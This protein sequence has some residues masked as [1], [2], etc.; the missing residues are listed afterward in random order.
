M[1]PSVNERPSARPKSG[2]DRLGTS[3]GP[4][5]L[6]P[7]I[8]IKKGQCIRAHHQKVEEAIDLLLLNRT[9]EKREE[10]KANS[11]KWGH[12]CIVMKDPTPVEEGRR[13]EIEA[14]YCTTSASGLL[15]RDVNVPLPHSSKLYE[16]YRNRRAPLEVKDGSPD[17]MRQTYVVPYETFVLTYDA[18]AQVKVIRLS[19]PFPLEERRLTTRRRRCI[20]NS[21]FV[22]K[23]SIGFSKHARRTK[24]T[25][26][27]SYQ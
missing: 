11:A 10:A 23:A 5:E 14:L 3:T 18:E 7:P 21:R 16:S 2:D 15:H 8:R 12:Y 17:F 25:L 20:R 24:S 13:F 22:M 4:W 19:S 6:T 1:S 9:E 26:R 27:R